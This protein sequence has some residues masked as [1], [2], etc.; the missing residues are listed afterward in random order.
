MTTK[1]LI[2]RLQEL[3]P[4]GNMEVFIPDEDDDECD[5]VYDT[6][7]FTF[8]VDDMKPV[9]PQGMKVGEKFIVV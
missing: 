1:E 8:G 9:I 7:V 6:R 2:K 3:D 4:E 5:T